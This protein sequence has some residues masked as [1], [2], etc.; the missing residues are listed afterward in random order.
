MRDMIFFC[1]II[2]A[3]RIF[4]R[5]TRPRWL[6]S[7]APAR[8][9][10]LFLLSSVF[11]T[12]F[13][14]LCPSKH[15][16][17][18]DVR[19]LSSPGWFSFTSVQFFRSGHACPSGPSWRSVDFIF[20]F[21]F[22][23]CLKLHE[24]FTYFSCSNTVTVRCAPTLRTAVNIRVAYVI[25]SSDSVVFTDDERRRPDVFSALKLGQSNKAAC[26]PSPLPRFAPS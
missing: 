7:V 11:E 26:S 18:S 25:L 8:H 9:D 24:D 20:I 6:T 22:E 2:H 3:K 12:G 13:A 14:L 1:S 15:G 17:E 21:K 16:G 5:L 10:D 23:S 4:L 19:L